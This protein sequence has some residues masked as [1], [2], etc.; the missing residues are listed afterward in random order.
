VVEDL[1]W[2][3]P[4]MLEFLEHLADRS[5]GL[6]LLVV[7]TA[8]PEL[9]ER[10]PGW[11]D[12]GGN[13][14]TIRLGS[15]TDAQTARLVAAL[16]GRSVL[17]ARVRALLLERAGGNPL[18]AEEFVRLLADRGLLGD[19][20]VAG[21]PEVPVP[22]TVH[23]LIAA[24]LDTPAPA[25]R[26]LLHDAAVVGRVFWSGA[27]AVM[28]GSGEDEVQAG[29]RELEHRRLVHRAATS[30][31]RYQDEFAF[32]HALVR[33]VAYAQIPRAG[34]ARRHRAAAEWL[35]TVAGERVADL[36]EVLAHHYG[37]A[38]AYARAAGEAE[39]QILE[40]TEAARRFLV[41]AGDRASNLDLD[42]AGSW[43]R[44]A[45]DLSPPGHP[46]RPG[47]LARAGRVA[48]QAGELAE[49]AAAYEAAIAGLRE[50]GDVRGLGAAMGRLATVRWN[51][52]D[53]RGATAVLT[54]AIE[55]LER[56][57]PSPSCARPTRAW[58]AT[59]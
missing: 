49:A 52:G 35:E 42:R 14:S 40:L 56:E 9:L 51:Q 26:A 4:A 6:P 48:F 53:T 45:L 36:A 31:V 20:Q 24:R 3:D 1:H 46:R 2:A 57:P 12:G 28:G 43:Y 39:P 5:T 33:D 58:P 38:L 47:L 13:A 15:L 30:S 17:P 50:Q 54:E 34:R 44:Q 29:L 16:A 22:E 18:Y 10:Q 25:A 41:L 59:G 23:G 27:V 7:A 55:L 32:W 21:A 37:Q 8:R 19:G 11:G